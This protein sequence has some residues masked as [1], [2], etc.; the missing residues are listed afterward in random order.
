MIACKAIVYGIA[1]GAM[2][3]LA[4]VM[5]LAAC[6]GAPAHIAGRYPCT[7][8]IWMLHSQLPCYSQRTHQIQGV[9]LADIDDVLIPP[10]FEERHILMVGK[11]VHGSAASL[12]A[13]N[14]VGTPYRR[15]VSDG[16]PRSVQ[17]AF[18]LATPLPFETP[19]LGGCHLIFESCQRNHQLKFKVASCSNNKTM[20]PLAWL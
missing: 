3:T 18:T 2:V 15:D 6:A 14:A 4:P 17:S 1:R 11:E 20:P 10:K 5:L 9:L 13:R 8:V 7:P 19:Q 12:L 16:E